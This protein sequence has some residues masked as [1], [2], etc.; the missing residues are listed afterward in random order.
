MN[1]VCRPSKPA[2]RER[3][4]SFRRHFP[5]ASALLLRTVEDATA[6]RTE[7]AREGIA[8]YILPARGASIF[9]G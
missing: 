2:P 7:D 1:S 4:F 5:K 6:S 8:L 9:V 3:V